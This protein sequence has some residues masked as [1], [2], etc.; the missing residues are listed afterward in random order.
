MIP[1]CIIG[2]AGGTVIVVFD[3]VPFASAVSYSFLDPTLRKNLGNQS[4]LLAIIGPLGS[5]TS[6][7]VMALPDTL[8]TLVD[9]GM[10]GY[11]DDPGK[12]I[13]DRPFDILRWLGKQGLSNHYLP[14]RNFGKYYFAS[15]KTACGK[16][17]E[18]TFLKE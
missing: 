12:D 1:S 9:L 14:T 8:I 4:I 2:V 17:L 3:T 15:G 16:F 13:Y 7:A 6:M 11:V 5:L 10:D 18:R